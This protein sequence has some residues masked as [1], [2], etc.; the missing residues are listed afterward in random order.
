MNRKYTKETYLALIQSIK[1][2]IPG[3]SITTD[4][5]VGFPGETEEDFLE[6]LDLVQQSG[7]EGAYTFVFSARSGTP[8]ASFEDDTPIE[9]K[10]QRLQRLNQVVN[11]QFKAGNERFENQIVE[12]LIDGFSKTNPNVLSGYTPHNKLVNVK[13]DASLI[14]KILS[15][16]I[17][18]AKTW[19]LD[20]EFVHDEA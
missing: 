5:I 20:G 15:V 14:G 3:V 8:A 17:K 1:Q 7:F 11:A 4:I 2:A 13:G 6:T 19:S 9:V 12:V 18:N 16:R 10:K